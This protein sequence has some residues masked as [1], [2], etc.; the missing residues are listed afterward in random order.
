MKR[1]RT[2]DAMMDIFQ[3]LPA[4]NGISVLIVAIILFSALL[5]F[6]RGAF[7]SVRQLFRFALDTGITLICLFLSWKLAAFYS[8][9]LADWVSRRNMEIPQQKLDIFSQIYY[10][11]VTGIRDFSIMRTSLVFIIAYLVIR[12]ILSLLLK[13]IIPKRDSESRRIARSRGLFAPFSSL[14]GGVLGAATGCGRA[15]LVVAVLFMFTS[16]MP[17][18]AFSD[19]V[20]QSQVY[21]QGA[22]RII[23]PLAGNWLA[24]R[25]PV[26]TR[27]VQGEMDQI[28]KRKYEVLD[29]HIPDNIAETAVSVTQDVSTEEAKARALYDWVGSRVSYDWDKYDQYVDHGIWKE[30]T[31]EETFATREGVCIDYAR[32]YAVM[33]K[34]AGLEVRVATG[35]GY[36][37]AGGYGPHA[38]NEVFIGAGGWVPLDS[39]WASGGGN[40]F[41][42]PDFAET[43]IE[44][45]V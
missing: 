3:S 13:W 31:P 35:L 38:W 7:S 45:S 37:G 41:N 26:F 2:A 21:R 6:H 32:L 11:F 44:Q 25:L 5:G 28:L 12:G 30:Q 10:T 34:A 19:Y 15:L 9:R 17:Q 14:V 43:H 8:P 33:A 20:R 42:P 4:I 22:D 16:L 39:T 1:E 40:W 29:A 18:S 27:A 23:G 36:D 24:D